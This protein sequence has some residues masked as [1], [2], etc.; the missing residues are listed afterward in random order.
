[1]LGGAV[2]LPMNL[3]VTHVNSSVLVLSRRLVGQF[4][5]V[6]RLRSPKKQRPLSRPLQLS[7]NQ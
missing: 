6:G 5:Q 3:A 1:M 2:E 4:A 7:F